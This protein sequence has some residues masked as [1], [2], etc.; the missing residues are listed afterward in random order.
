MG[1]SMIA[2]REVDEEV[3]RRFKARVVEE[4]MKLGR[5]LTL[6]MEMWLEKKKERKIDPRNLL[7]MSGIIKTK[8]KVKWSEE[9]DQFLYGLEK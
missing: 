6:A 4:K 9:I 2:V 1:K 5:A 7:K 3:F 8:K